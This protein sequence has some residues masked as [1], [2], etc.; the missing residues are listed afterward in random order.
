MPRSVDFLIRIFSLFVL[1]FVLFCLLWKTV[2]AFDIPDF[3][4]CVNPQGTVI[5]SYSSGTHGIPGDYTTHEGTDAVYAVNENQALQCFCATDG[6]G[7]QTNWWKT[8]SLTEEEKSQL[9][10]AGWN[11]IPDGRAWGLDASSYLAKNYQY[12]CLFG[13]RGGGEVLGASTLGTGGG[14]I[15]G[16]AGTGNKIQIYL[17]IAVGILLISLGLMLRKQHIFH[18]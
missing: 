5:A 9:L 10:A 14:E 6:N 11:Y 2:L 12:D 16:F 4:L 3:P 15:L 18:S 1:S 17:S 8:D 7:I 13:G